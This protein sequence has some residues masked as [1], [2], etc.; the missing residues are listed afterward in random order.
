MNNKNWLIILIVVLIAIGIHNWEK[1]FQ[2]SGKE[3]LVENEIG[4]IIIDLSGE[5]ACGSSKD[6]E[7]SSSRLIDEGVF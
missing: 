5:L 4:K 7:Y 6:F 3:M 2:F 1:D